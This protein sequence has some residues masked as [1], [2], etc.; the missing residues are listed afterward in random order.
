MALLALLLGEMVAFGV[1]GILLWIRVIIGSLNMVMFKYE[2]K[3]WDDEE[4]SSDICHVQGYNYD[5]AVKQLEK[6]M[7]H[8]DW[9]IISH[10]VIGKV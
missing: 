5:D 1:A 2:I 6:H 9:C 10:R 3:I 8:D 4:L 7:Q